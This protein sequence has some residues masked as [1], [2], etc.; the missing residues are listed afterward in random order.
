MAE[1]IIGVILAAILSYA[2]V[3]LTW[4]KARRHFTGQPSQGAGERPG[5][6]TDPRPQLTNSDATNR[7]S[8]E[9][10]AVQERHVADA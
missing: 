5:S 8:A 7:L 9:P 10:G 6:G 3:V 2:L 1:I 4:E